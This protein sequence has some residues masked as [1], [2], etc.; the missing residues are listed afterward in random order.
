[1]SQ[2]ITTP[3]DD[4]FQ[5]F[6]Q[7][8]DINLSDYA[9][10]DKH[11]RVYSIANA[12]TTPV[13]VYPLKTFANQQDLETFINELV[14]LRYAFKGTWK[15]VIS[16][17]GHMSFDE[18]WANTFNNKPYTP[19]A[20]KE[21][22]VELISSGKMAIFPLNEWIPP[23]D[24][25]HHRPPKVAST[26]ALVEQVSKAVSSPPSEE[27]NWIDLEYRYADGSGVGG[28]RYSVKDA[29]SGA[30][31]AS[32]QLGVDG[33]AYVTLPLSATAVTVEYSNDPALNKVL[34]PTE[35]I[36]KDT[37]TGWFERMGKAVESAW[38][39][40]TDGLDWA[41]GTLQGDFNEN[42]TSGQIITNA[43]VTM[44]PV[45]DQI[46]DARDIVAN[47]KLL[48]WDKRYNEF[49]VWLALF[50]TLIGLIPVLGSALKGVLKLVWKGAK[51]DELLNVFN[52]F[53][54]GNGVKWLRELQGGKLKQ[55]ASEAADIG[56]QVFDA[57]WRGFH[58]RCK[59]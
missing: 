48:V 1:M 25:N 36:I 8:K 29:N 44:I 47:L 51:L 43:V 56:H 55:Y 53:M 18:R 27:K 31:L 21:A 17:N 45:V 28:A 14:F 42:P 35:P 20:A 57:I 19:E 6:R 4:P 41:W 38:D 40:T 22:I 5:S 10:Y 32:G 11:G 9:A 15:H 7:T 39:S 34:A 13:C 46:A 2:D 59:L 54:K 58:V 37:H 24:R 23:G 33:T 26:E 3:G 16:D 50:F 49:A 12:S 30:E 52:W